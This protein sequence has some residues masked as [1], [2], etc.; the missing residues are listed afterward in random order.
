M[1]LERL[2]LLAVERGDYQEA[3]NIFKRSLEGKKTAPGW[4]GLGLA[5]FHLED[6]A[7]ARWAFY[8]SLG[9]RAHDPQARAYLKKTEALMARPA[10]SAGPARGS[11]FRASKDSLEIDERGWK[12][13]FVKGMNIGLG[14][15]GSY[16]GEYAIRKKTYIEWFGL[17]SDLGINAIRVYTLH[18]PS[19]YE[20]LC[21]FNSSGERL[22]L[23]QGIWVELPGDHDMLDAGFNRR[24]KRDTKNTVDALFG[25]AELSERP[26]YPHGAYECDVS[27]WTAGFI[28]GREWES[29]A[30]AGFNE[31]QRRKTGD[32]EGRT[33][34]IERASPFERWLVGA[35]DFLQDYELG[36]YGLSHPVSTVNW[37]TLDPLVHPSESRYEDETLF[38]F[39]R[40]KKVDCNENE[41]VESLDLTGVKPLKGAGFFATYHAYPYYPDFMNN[42]YLAEREPYLAYLR[43]IKAVHGETPVML[44]EFGVPSSREV[45]HW[46]RTGYNQGGHNEAAQGELN[47]ELMRKIH[48]SGMAG[49]M[50]FAWF[51][52]WFKRNWVF[53]PYERPAERNAFWFNSQDAEQNYGVMAAYPGYPAKK[54]T[55]SNRAK[56]WSGARIL[57]TSLRAAPT[58]G[59]GDG[60]D[61]ARSFKSLS[62]RHDE[63][64][65][66]LRIETAGDVDFE[67]AHYLVGIDTCEP[68]TGEFM[69]PFSTRLTSPVGL[70][71]LVCL[72]G[73]KSSRILACHSYDKYLNMNA[74]TIRPEA[75]HAG[76]W[77]VMQNKTNAR[78]MSKDFKRYFPSRV[79]SMSNLR[80]GSLRR[81]RADYDSA[82]DFYAKGRHLEVR[83]PWGLMNFTD[84]SS[85]SV[86]WK[87][88][89][90]WTRK[91]DG[92]RLLVF[93]YKPS[94][95]GLLASPTGRA[96]NITDS[97]PARL[98]PEEVRTYRWKG[99]NTPVF[100]TYL[101]DSYY[102]YKKALK[103]I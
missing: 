43:A 92:V 56:E 74:G 47:G 95:A 76:A 32:F 58:F 16:P 13:F 96:V 100:H 94:G 39:G 61:R 5:F 69:L 10:Q 8:K 7:A 4:F 101:K 57:Y 36:R 28:F 42:D 38:Q 48:A 33:L 31:T 54:V 18:M 30:V 90:R 62:V 83:L 81:G 11:V 77:V 91:T 52:E 63:G 80:Y 66:Y 98:A 67:R 78:R 17:I 20:A 72:T 75:S 2:G 73:K 93:S 26:G 24:V 87:E 50:L 99:W 21:E 97:L 12:R 49:G 53:M 25:N 19:F 82:A 103:E 3:M 79:F 34:S 37:P 45:T 68:E 89:E 14:I 46:N 88:G 6:Y 40:V 44:A 64:F 27:A 51:D 84:P 9:L 85:R 71:F 22:Y 65:L 59:F 29:C 15:P 35:C 23:F 70:K 41:D 86:L 102:A 60:A 55:L 1:N